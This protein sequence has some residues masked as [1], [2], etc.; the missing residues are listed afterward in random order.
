MVEA[1]IATLG[2][3]DTAT[4]PAASHNRFPV[5]RMLGSLL[6]V[7]GK[8]WSPSPSKVPTPVEGPTLHPAQHLC[9]SSPG[10]R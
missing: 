7:Y 8:T 3:T 10:Q 4:T 1:A 5:T 9:N 6:I 2:Q